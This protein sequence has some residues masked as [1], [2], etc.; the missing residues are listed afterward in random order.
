MRNDIEVLTTDMDSVIDVISTCCIAE[1]IEE[2]EW[3]V[4]VKGQLKSA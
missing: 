4:A 1:S 3:V 2:S